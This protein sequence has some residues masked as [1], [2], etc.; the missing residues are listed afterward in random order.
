MKV[1]GKGKFKFHETW[2][3]PEDI[4]KFADVMMS[5]VGGNYWHE[6]EQCWKNKKWMHIFCGESFLGDIRV[7][8]NKKRNVT[9]VIDYKN[10]VKEFGEQSQD[11]LI[12]DPPWQINYLERMQISYIVR[13]LLKINGFA[14]FNC[15]W[16]PWCVGFTYRSCWIPM[17]HFNNYKDL[18]MWWIMQKNSEKGVLKN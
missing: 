15:T 14:L 12:L 17:P 16:N 6:K 13:D 8:I 7:D 4:S 5:K 10:L 11:N 1:I 9:H 3:F 18:R 2:K